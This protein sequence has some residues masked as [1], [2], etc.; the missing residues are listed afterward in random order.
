M[1]ET[2]FSPETREVLSWACIAVGFMVVVGVIAYCFTPKGAAE[3]DYSCPKCGARQGWI[4]PA[5]RKDLDDHEEL[6][7]WCAR[8]RYEKTYPTLD[9]YAKGEAA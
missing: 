3:P 8:C 5:Y 6:V 7:T 2:V 4:G 1:M 9:A